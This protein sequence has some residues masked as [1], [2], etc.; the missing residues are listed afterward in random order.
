M[1][2]IDPIHREN[3]AKLAAHLESLPADYSHFRMETFYDPN[4]HWWDDAGDAF[5]PCGSVACAVGHG[6]AA[7]I[8]MPP[9]G[10]VAMY[11]T[12][13]VAKY[14]VGPLNWDDYCNAYLCDPASDAWSFMFGGQWSLHDNSHQGAAARI[15]HFLEHGLP[16]H[17]EWYSGPW[18]RT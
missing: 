4:F 6:P 3:L 12:G 1:D 2:T 9:L 11:P 7:G 15:R 14:S 18:L 8:G 5:V 13:N 10:T 16:P 17:E